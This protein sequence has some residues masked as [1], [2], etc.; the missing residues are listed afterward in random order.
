MVDTRAAW[1]PFRCGGG[2]CRCCLPS[3]ST[4]PMISVPM[5]SFPLDSAWTTRDLF[6]VAIPPCSSER[7]SDDDPD[8]TNRTR[9]LPAS[10]LYSCSAA[11]P[12]PVALPSFSTPCSSSPLP[13]SLSSLSSSWSQPSLPHGAN[14]SASPY[15]RLHRRINSVFQAAGPAGQAP[16]PASLDTSARTPTPTTA[17]ACR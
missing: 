13:S 17:S 12:G 6:P 4:E 2:R 15:G 9:R 14:V 16:L 10:V 8:P 1:R 3:S 7:F 11:C 5:L